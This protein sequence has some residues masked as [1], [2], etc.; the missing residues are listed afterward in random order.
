[1]SDKLRIVVVDDQE[2]T[3]QG[4][5]ALLGFAE[6]MVVI[7]EACDGREALRIVAEEQPDVVLMDVRMPIMDGLQATRQIKERWPPVKV[8]VM[9]LYPTHKAQAREAGADHVLIKGSDYGSLEDVIREV[10][11]HDV[12]KLGDK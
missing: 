4:L 1:M 5:K 3:R 9:T 2:P 12:Q 10:A 11:S 6:D 8:I 7:Q